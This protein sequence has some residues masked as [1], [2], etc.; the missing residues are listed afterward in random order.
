MFELLQENPNN[1]TSVKIT[2]PKAIIDP[3]N[4]IIEIFDS[5]VD[6]F[7]KNGQDINVKSGNSTLNNITNNI[8]VF[9]N[10]KIAFLGT[11]DYYLETNSFDLDLNTSYIYINNPLIISLL[12]SYIIGEKGAYNIDSSE[13]KIVSTEFRRNL[14][15][16]DGEEEYQVKIK[17]D[18][19]NWF[20]NDNI[21][22][23]TSSE[24]QVETTIDF[25]LTQ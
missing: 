16:S 3:T 12:N 23:F 11:Q 20:K 10:V 21:L 8:R 14:Y 24:K 25:L 2:S 17:S 22:V 19:A 4:S 9:N 5:S 15:N 18:L 1:G 7:N 6:I 13:F